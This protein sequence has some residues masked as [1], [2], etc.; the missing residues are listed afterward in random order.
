MENSRKIQLT[1]RN[2]YTVSLPHEWIK[3]LGL[4][5]GNHV[6]MI[7]NDDGTILLSTKHI[8]K[9]PVNYRINVDGDDKIATMRSIVSAYINGAG[10]ITLKGK[11]VSSIAEHARQLLSGVEIIDEAE[12]EMTLKIMAFEELDPNS[13]I[14]RASNVTKSMFVFASD[15]CR[16]GKGNTLEIMRKE[17]EVDR[18]YVLLLRGLVI[19]TAPQKDALF[20]AIVAKSIEKVGDHIL[21]LCD[22]AKDAGK[23]EWLADLVDKAAEVYTHAIESYFDGNLNNPKYKAAKA[24]YLEAYKKMDGEIDRQKNLAK[25]LILLMLLERCNK[26][27]RYSD[28]IMESNADIAFASM[29]SDKKG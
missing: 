12:E 29:G 22:N 9:E 23:N 5:K 1:G 15:I 18:L 11:E 8:E 14:R 20:K 19:G 17:E 28:D 3:K 24:K 27:I 10:K 13:I 26:I 4:G 16:N 7:N 25:R 2:T 21:D 6:Y